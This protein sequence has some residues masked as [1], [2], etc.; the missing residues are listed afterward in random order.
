MYENASNEIACAAQP[1]LTKAD[2]SIIA[3]GVAVVALIALLLWVDVILHKQL[4]R[5]QDRKFL[6]F[7]KRMGRNEEEEK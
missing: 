5:E 7:M 2:L 6:E 4:I 1:Y 3:V